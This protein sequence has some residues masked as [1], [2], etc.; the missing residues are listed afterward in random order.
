M[1]KSTHLEKKNLND[2]LNIKVSPHPLLLDE[3]ERIKKEYV[4]MLMNVDEVKEKLK[5]VHGNN[6]TSENIWYEIL[7]N[8]NYYENCKEI[9][10]FALRLL[11]RSLNECS[12]EVEVSIIGSI[13]TH[14][15]PL[16]HDT[17]NR[18]NF[19]KSNGP[20]ILF[21]MK[22]VEDALNMHFGKGKKWH[23]VMSQSKYVTSKAIDNI[24]KEAESEPNL[25]S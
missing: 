11:T 22:V 20:H 3:K 18:L 17:V 21:S 10:N 9:N 13:E 1:S 2:L 8:E 14:R 6:L 7:S 16:H 5:I 15:R 4:T 23:F 25:L 24:F 19:I 12:V